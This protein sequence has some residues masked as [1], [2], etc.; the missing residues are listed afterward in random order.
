[1]MLTSIRVNKRWILINFT[2][3]NF[4]NFEEFCPFKPVKSSTTVLRVRT[5]LTFF[6][7]MFEKK[8]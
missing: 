6:I 7:K 8:V 3:S 4:Y 5:S 1:M 2:K